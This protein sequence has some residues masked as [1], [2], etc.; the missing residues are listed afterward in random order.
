MLIISKKLNQI[1][2]SNFG[3]NASQIN[4]DTNLT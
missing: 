1:L 4:N 3:I 2:K